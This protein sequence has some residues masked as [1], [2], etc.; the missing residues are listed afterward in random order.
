MTV[1]NLDDKVS[2]QWGKLSLVSPE[3]QVHSAILACSRDILNGASESRLAQWRSLF[4]TVTLRVV[5]LTPDI[6]YFHAVSLRNKVAADYSGL[7]RTTFQ[8]V[9][10]ICLF[11]QRAEATQGKALTNAAVASAYNE[12]AKRAET[13]EELTETFVDSAL[14]VWSRACSIPV[15]LQCLKQCD[16]DYGHRS[17]FNSITKL[18]TIVSKAKTPDNIKWSFLM[19]EDRFRYQM[20]PRSGALLSPANPTRP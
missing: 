6:R 13:Q 20:I 1:A 18:Q 14:S 2:E 10:E 8:E 7:A 4:L 19:L 12:A 17:I 9:C 15:V 3:E 5:V 11:K 16:E